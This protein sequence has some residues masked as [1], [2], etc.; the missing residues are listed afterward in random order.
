MQAV[1]SKL[2]EKIKQ[3]AR[4]RL[5]STEADKDDEILLASLHHATAERE[6]LE[7]LLAEIRDQLARYA[8]S[9]GPDALS[10]E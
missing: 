2:D 5:L 9:Q 7:F 1:G 8:P 3:I 10:G 4:E 6:E